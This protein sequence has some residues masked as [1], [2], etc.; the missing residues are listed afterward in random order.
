[1]TDFRGRFSRVLSRPEVYLA[2]H[3]L[4]R[5]LDQ[6]SRDVQEGLDAWVNGMDSAWQLWMAEF[7]R[8]ERNILALTGMSG[9]VVHKNSVGQ[10]L[11]AVLNALPAPVRVVTSASEF[12]SVDFILREYERRSLVAVDWVEPSGAESGISKFVAEDFLNR[13]VPG[14]GLVIVS[15]VIFT[16]G[17]VVPG[18][19]E[20]I[21]KAHEVGAKVFLDS[22]HAAGVFPWS[23]PDADFVAGGSYKYLRGGPGACWLVVHPR[24]LSMQTLDTGWFAKARTF[25]FLKEDQRAEGGKGWWEST[26]SP[27]PLFQ[28][29]SGLEFTLEVGVSEIR[30][31]TLERLRALRD[32]LASLGGFD[33]QD[34]A[35]WGGFCL[36]PSPDSANIVATLKEQGINVDARQGIVRFGPDLLTTPEEI[37]KTVGACQTLSLART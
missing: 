4:G 19:T 22:Y 37:E 10:G 36:V 11:R 21:K 14:V 15:L 32:G 3:S 9:A 18:V 28:A 1:M 33:P 31:L 30:R 12:D 34:E 13:I 2:N 7:E 17:Q 26:P 6:M 8:F 27:L 29:R 5:P 20:I 16:T 23:Y 35:E 25:D 24:N